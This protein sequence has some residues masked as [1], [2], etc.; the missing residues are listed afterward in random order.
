MS[1]PTKCL[2]TGA[3]GFIG[4]HLVDALLARGDT[5]IG[6]DNL[7]LGRRTHLAQAMKNSRFKFYEADVNDVEALG[8]MVVAESP[9]APIELAWHMAANSDIRAGVED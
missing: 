5:V 3:A 2:V 1:T 7:K 4:S 6:V 8:A 9:G